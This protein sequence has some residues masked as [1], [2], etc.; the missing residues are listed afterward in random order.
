MTISPA[1]IHYPKDDMAYGK[2]FNPTTN[3]KLLNCW[4]AYVSLAKC[5]LYWYND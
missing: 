2:H 3:T 4:V 1:E 5:A